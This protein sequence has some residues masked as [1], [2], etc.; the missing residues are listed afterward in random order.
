VPPPDEQAAIA[1]IL[2]AVDT[3]LER[4]RTTL[5][6]AKALAISLSDAAVAGVLLNPAIRSHEGEAWIHPRLGSIQKLGRSTAF[7]KRVHELSTAPIK[8]F[9][10]AERVCLFF[11]YLVLE[12]VAFFGRMPA[13]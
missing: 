13:K 7:V 1:R 4:T 3:A 12:K 9:R 2:D 8:L 6:A 5:V 11:M 10:R